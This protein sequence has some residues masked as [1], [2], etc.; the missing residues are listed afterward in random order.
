M[1]VHVEASGLFIVGLSPTSD[2]TEK[3]KYNIQSKTRKISF[4]SSG[5]IIA[6]SP[7]DQVMDLENR[8]SK[9]WSGDKSHHQ[10]TATAD[11]LIGTF[12]LSELLCSFP[13]TNL[14]QWEPVS[15]PIFFPFHWQLS[16]CPIRHG[17]VIFPRALMNQRRVSIWNTGCWVS[18]E[19]RLMSRR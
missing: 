8:H 11:F 12:Y 7:N 5:I 16:S 14:L 17:A 1:A 9:R 19:A 13:M 3:R 4:C 10:F 6:C 15:W 2:Q 18:F